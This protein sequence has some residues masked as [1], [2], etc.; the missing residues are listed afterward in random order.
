MSNDGHKLDH[1]VLG[2]LFCV[3]TSVENEIRQRDSRRQKISGTIR[4]PDFSV[5]IQKRNKSSRQR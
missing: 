2:M 5:K 1:H 4:C 3:W